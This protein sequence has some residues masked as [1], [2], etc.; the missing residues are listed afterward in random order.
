FYARGY[1]GVMNRA[2]YMHGYL[3]DLFDRPVRAPITRADRFRMT[4]E[5]LN[6]RRFVQLLQAESCDL[7]INTH[8]LP[9]GIIAAMRRQGKIATPQVT[10]TTDYDTH[11]MWVHLPCEH[12]F[13]AAEE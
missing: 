8:F 4:V 1:L 6:L 3:Y 9:A 7:V 13:T 5:R 12:Y 10:V 2:P 11:R